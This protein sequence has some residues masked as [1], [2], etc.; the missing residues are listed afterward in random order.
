MKILYVKEGI[1]V[2]K[3]RPRPS[4]LDG[5]GQEL[6]ILSQVHK[7]RHLLLFSL[8]SKLIVIGYYLSNFNRACV[9][10]NLD[11]VS[12]L[13]F[14]QMLVTTHFRQEEHAYIPFLLL[15]LPRNLIRTF[16]PCYISI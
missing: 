2:G 1:F 3:L 10:H 8:P 5:D 11:K 9:S 4:I 12:V 7:V 14:S 6:K 15:Y 16:K 13:Y